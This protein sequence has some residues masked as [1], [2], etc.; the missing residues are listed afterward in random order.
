MRIGEFIRKWFV[1]PVTE[2][3]QIRIKLGPLVLPLRRALATPIQ[4]LR[5]QLHARYGTFPKIHDYPR[6]DEGAQPKDP[7]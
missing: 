1:V 7:H 2:R 5:E 6:H 3:P 4:T